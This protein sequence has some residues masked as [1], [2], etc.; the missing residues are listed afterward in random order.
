MWI[1][2]ECF[3]GLP[4]FLWLPKPPTS[5]ANEV[6]DSFIWYIIVPKCWLC[7]VRCRSSLG[8][9]ALSV[10]IRKSHVGQRKQCKWDLA[11]PT[12]L[13]LHTPP[14]EHLTNPM[15]LRIDCQAWRNQCSRQESTSPLE[16][17]LASTGGLNLS[18]GSI[19]NVSIQPVRKQWKWSIPVEW[20][21]HC[22]LSQEDSSLK[23][24]REGLT[25][26]R[27]WS[28][29][30]ESSQ[31]FKGE[32]EHWSLCQHTSASFEARFKSLT[33]ELRSCGSKIGETDCGGEGLGVVV[34]DVVAVVVLAVMFGATTASP[35]LFSQFSGGSMRWFWGAM[36]QGKLIDSRLSCFL[37]CEEIWLVE[38]TI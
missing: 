26:S 3:G 27:I 17:V 36:V 38:W 15:I 34:A 8:A 1:S 12:P 4:L 25:A 11:L 9:S 24:F 30:A 29:S 20:R 22:S 28:T 18:S 19:S 35:L 7:L 10:S 31:S 14:P 16:I 37:L 21:E 32:L 33:E 5:E 6:D 2:R 13:G 23:S